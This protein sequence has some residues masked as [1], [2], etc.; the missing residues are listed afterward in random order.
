MINLQDQIDY[1]ATVFNNKI[2]FVKCIRMLNIQESYRP[3]HV[4]KDLVRW[5]SNYGLSIGY[6]KVNRM[7]LVKNT[8]LTVL[9]QATGDV[10][11]H[12][13]KLCI[14]KKIKVN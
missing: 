14:Q 13:F 10:G 11:E 4:A 1:Q 12:I 5:E 2:D 9:F 7:V 3:T 8:H 6:N